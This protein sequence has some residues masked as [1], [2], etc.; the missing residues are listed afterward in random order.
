LVKKE[1]TKMDKQ[2]DEGDIGKRVLI[3]FNPNEV[4]IDMFNQESYQ[5]PYNAILNYEFQTIVITPKAPRILV[6]ERNNK[7]KIVNIV[8]IAK[9]L[10]ASSVET[11]GDI[12]E[13][14]EDYFKIKPIRKR[15]RD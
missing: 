5:I 13:V 8:K 12:V 11:L 2:F 10:G 9:R 15:G 1:A 7:E 3:E 6:Y 4:D 14:A